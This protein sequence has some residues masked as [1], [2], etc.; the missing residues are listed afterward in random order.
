MTRRDEAL[1]SRPPD[2]IRADRKMELRMRQ[3]G[4]VKFFNTDRGFGFITPDGGGKDVFVHVTALERSGLK[5][6]REGQ[7]LSFELENDRRGRG[8]QAVNLEAV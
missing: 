7:K 3:T 8:P 5:Q 1:A 6:V 4:T 2:F